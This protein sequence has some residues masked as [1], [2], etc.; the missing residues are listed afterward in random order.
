M[1]LPK[2]KIQ[3]RGLYDL[4]IKHIALAMKVSEKD[5]RAIMKQMR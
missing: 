3:K 5:A 2:V 1:K 4:F